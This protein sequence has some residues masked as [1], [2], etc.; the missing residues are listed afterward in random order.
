MINA[1]NYRSLHKF[2]L[3]FLLFR[4]CFEM[5]KL[6]FYDLLT[7]YWCKSVF[8]CVWFVAT[9]EWDVLW[10]CIVFL[11]IIFLFYVISSQFS[12]ISQV[13]ENYIEKL[14]NI[15]SVFFHATLTSKQMVPFTLFS[16]LLRI[17]NKKFVKR[18]T[19]FPRNFP[20]FDF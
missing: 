18:N 5:S 12:N 6:W 19:I 7:G 2:R 10:T 8:L 16:S 9:T 3:Y 15:F 4:I 17:Q 11:F 20:N 14:Y 13:L 1:L